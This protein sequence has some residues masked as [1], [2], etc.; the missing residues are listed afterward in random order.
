M[1][2]GIIFDIK[3]LTVHDGPGIRVTVFF[4][5]CPLRCMWCHNPE[6]LFTNPQIMKTRNG[7]VDC[8]KC[9]QS[10]SHIECGGMGVCLKICPNGLVRTVGE[11][12]ESTDLAEQLKKH[13]T[14]FETSGGGVTISGG[15]PLMQPQFLLDLLKELM[16]VHTVLQ[17]SGYGDSAVFEEAA[18]VADLVLFD[19]KLADSAKHLKYIGVDNELIFRN[20]EVLKTLN[21]FFIVR[22]PII[23]G[24][25]DT[26]EHFLEI[27]KLIKDVKNRVNVEILPYN[28]LAGAKYASVG[29][30]FQMNI[31]N[32]ATANY[33]TD[34]FKD[35]GIVASV[36]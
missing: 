33:N 19:I 30:Q 1:S 27:A 36:L 3:E 4:K 15:E 6:G 22:L 9:E 31:E 17:T 32:T 20:L 21:K 13:V 26:D 8:G 12:V 10:C 24:V 28:P 7:C 11:V 29:M 23:P 25:N 35:A 18:S 2:H 34:I 16:P 5:G 14:V